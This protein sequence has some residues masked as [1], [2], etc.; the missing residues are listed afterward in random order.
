[1]RYVYVHTPF[2]RNN[3]NQGIARN[4]LRKVFVRNQLY[5]KVRLKIE[6]KVVGCKRLRSGGPTPSL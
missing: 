2:H 3:F 1:M 4:S 6:Q 5:G